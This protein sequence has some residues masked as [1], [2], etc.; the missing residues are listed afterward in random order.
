MKTV[1]TLIVEDD[2][3]CRE[4]IVSQLTNRGFEVTQA[5]DG[6]DAYD[7]LMGDHNY[8]VALLD[9]NLPTMDGLKIL[10][11]VRQRQS[12]SQLPI[13]LMSVL[14]QREDVVRGLN[15]G[16]NDYISKPIEVTTLMARVA[17][18]AALKRSCEDLVNAERQRVMMESLGAA[19][20]HLSQPLTSAMGWI[21]HYTET[22]SVEQRSE[23]EG[24]EEVMHSMQE[25]AKIVHAMQDLREYRTTP[26]VEGHHIVDIGLPSRDSHIGG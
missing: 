22:L 12:P 15:M 11:E 3:L 14:S 18:C 17:A 26:Y 9:I 7:L 16:A 8:D 21:A 1:H 6:M 4:V 23:R 19:C 13:I 25:A 10:A 24:L 20:H 2:S 5:I